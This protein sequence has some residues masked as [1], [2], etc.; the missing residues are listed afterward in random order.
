MPEDE[1]PG[2][3]PPSEAYIEGTT[4]VFVPRGDLTE[5]VLARYLA[6]CEQVIAKAGHY[7][8]LIDLS[9][10]GSITAG[11]RK[12]SAE[13]ARRRPRA[14]SHIALFG[15]NAVRK[16]LVILVMRAV[17]L[18]SGKDLSARFFATE[19]DAR[20]WLATRP[21]GADKEAGAGG[22]VRRD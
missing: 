3:L 21:C 10:L 8:V 20:A 5:D 1:R 6:C 17:Q 12:R 14:A 7:C 13:W 16:A 9:Q 2:P 22:D 18:V 15:G 19:A 11:T 4:V